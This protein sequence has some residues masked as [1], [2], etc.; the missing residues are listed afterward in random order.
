M[1]TKRRYKELVDRLKRASNA[2]NKPLTNL[3]IA[4]SLGYTREYF[5][6]LLGPKGKVSDNHITD[7][8]LRYPYLEDNITHVISK[9]SD[10][11][12]PYIDKRRVQKSN[13]DP[14]LVP[15]VDVPAQAGYT[16][17]YQQRDYIASLKKYPILP[18]VDPT[19][20]VWRYFQIEGDSM[21]PEIM[22]GD[23]IL[24]SQVH[25]EDWPSIKDYHTHVIVTDENL[26]IKDV[27]KDSID[28]WLLLSQNPSYKAFA[29]KTNEIKQ[30]WV[31]RRHIKARAKKS[32]MYDIEEIR[33]QIKK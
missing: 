26:W 25:K 2:E 12:T 30:V 5:Q 20:A 27:Y 1:E 24:A 15:F 10:E 8:L 19:G 23:T 21:E 4:K 9:L 17:A 11:T 33:R 16:K 13:D 3:D 32:R 31:M 22:G 7:L 28:E 6:T 18:D 29:V 14:Y